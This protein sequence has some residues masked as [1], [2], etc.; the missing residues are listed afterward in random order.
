MERSITMRRN[1]PY[2]LIG[3]LA[4][5]VVI[6]GYLYYQ[7]RQGGIDIEIGKE[8]VRIEGQ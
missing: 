8:G 2:L 6:V 1:L 7:E 4:L 3:L 5:A